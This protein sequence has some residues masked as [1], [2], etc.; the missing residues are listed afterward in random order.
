MGTNRLW[1]TLSAFNRSTRMWAPIPLGNAQSQVTQRLS[2]TS[3]NID[4]WT[5][6]P[7]LISWNIDAFSSRPSHV[8][9]PSSV[10]ILDGPKSPD[11]IFLQEVTPDVRPLSSDDVRASDLG[12]GRPFWTNARQGEPPVRS[13]SMLI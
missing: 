4:T 11:I 2:L 8:P 7:S 10:I 13:A 5:Q 12:S 3:Q 9:N 1:R 6:R